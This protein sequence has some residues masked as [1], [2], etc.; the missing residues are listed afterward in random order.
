MVK[1]IA[2]KGKSTESELVPSKLRNHARKKQSINELSDPEE[3]DH[4]TIIAF[5]PYYLYDLQ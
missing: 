4:V 5:A 2:K 1:N 3:S